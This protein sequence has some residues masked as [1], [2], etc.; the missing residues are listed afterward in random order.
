MTDALTIHYAQALA[1]A[2][3]APGAEITPDQARAQLKLAAQ[4]VAES[5]DLRMALLSPSVSKVRKLAIVGKLSDQLGLHRLIKNFFLVVV[6]HRRVHELPAMQHDFDLIVDE[7]T[8]WIPAEITTAEELTPEQRGD[9]ERALGL[10][11]GKFIRAR[12]IVNPSVIGGVRAHVASK[13]YDTTIRGKLDSMR[14][15]LLSRA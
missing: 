13:E 6:S 2:V 15:R 5:N 7:R 10:K 1:D 11:T 12:Y 9:I 4:M 14:S 3:L 8:G